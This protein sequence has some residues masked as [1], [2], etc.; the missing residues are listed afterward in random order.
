[1]KYPSTFNLLVL[2]QYKAL[3]FISTTVRFRTYIYILYVSKFN[4]LQNVTDCVL[5]YSV[6]DT[7]TKK[8]ETYKA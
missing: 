8:Q 2:L 4:P 1:M 6:L 5:Y 3:D 7:H